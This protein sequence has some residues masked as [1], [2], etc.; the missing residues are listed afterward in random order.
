M[1]ILYDVMTH[2]LHGVPGDNVQVVSM[3]GM[4]YLFQDSKASG[5]E[6]KMAWLGDFSRNN[7]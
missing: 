5:L 4:K 3:L 7:H 6:T 2:N 1:W